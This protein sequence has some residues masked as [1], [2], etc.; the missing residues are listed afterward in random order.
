[1]PGEKDPASANSS[2][3]EE[4]TE[5]SPKSGLSK[6]LLAKWVGCVGLGRME[7]TEIGEEAQ[8]CLL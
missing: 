1:M 3:S 5:E 2:E 7:S 4:V 8:E 6:K